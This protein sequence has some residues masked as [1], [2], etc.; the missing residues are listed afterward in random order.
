MITEEEH[1]NKR[2]EFTENYNSYLEN[3]KKRKTR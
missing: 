3:K 2:K 1:Y